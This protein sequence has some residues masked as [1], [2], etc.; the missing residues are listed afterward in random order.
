MHTLQFTQEKNSPDVSEGRIGCDPWIN[1]T[2]RDFYVPQK[3]DPTAWII[4]TLCSMQEAPL[5]G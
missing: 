3:S 1:Q 5:F 4:K 2:C